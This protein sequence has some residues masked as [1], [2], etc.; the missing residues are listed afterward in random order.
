MGLKEKLKLAVG[1]ATAADQLR[2]K[3]DE[4]TKLDRQIEPLKAAWTARAKELEAARDAAIEDADAYGARDAELMAHL[5]APQTER[6]R[7]EKVRAHALAAADLPALEHAVKVERFEQF[8][9]DAER[10][11]RELLDQ[12]KQF[13]ADRLARQA[14]DRAAS[15]A[16]DDATGAAECTFAA[17]RSLAAKLGA[18]VPPAAQR[19]AAVLRT[20]A[21]WIAEYT[22][23]LPE[24]VEQERAASDGSARAHFAQ[25]REQLRADHHRNLMQLYGFGMTQDHQAALLGYSASEQLAD[26]HASPDRF[27]ERCAAVH[28]AESER[29]EGQKRTNARA[30]R[31]KLESQ[32]REREAK[33]GLPFLELPDD[34]D[35]VPEHASAT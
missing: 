26:L 24:L 33:M 21:Q 30:A 18:E 10:Q 17:V 13:V 20:A 25:R 12:A 16:L 6:E 8:K 11:R 5:N 28:R 19:T 14:A 4:I 29:A 31:A 7:L 1:L 34:D 22:A 35:D 2:A 9:A 27:L 3:E 32:M 15:A 23:A